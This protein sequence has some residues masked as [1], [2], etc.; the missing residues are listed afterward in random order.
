MTVLVKHD[1][2]CPGKGF[3]HSDG[4]KRIYDTY[5]L[6]RTADLYGAVG[7]WFAAS[8]NDG[9]TDGHTYPNRK[10]AIRHQHHNEQYYT[11]IQITPANM[12][13]CSA[14]VM[15]TVARRLYS[16]GFRITDPDD[17]RREPIKRTNAED[18]MAF[19]YRGVVTNVDFPS[20]N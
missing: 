13:V 3:G 11:Y 15:L 10:E 4:A 5:H 17:A 12:T 1:K 16:K 14:E 7:Q 8:L 9:T 18:Q 2:D 20:V 6:H 19:A